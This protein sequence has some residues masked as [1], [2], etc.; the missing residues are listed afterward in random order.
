MREPGSRPSL[1]G[2]VMRL[3]DD[4]VLLVRSELRLVFGE[5][6]QRLAQAVFVQQGQ[7]V[8]VQRGVVVGRGG[9]GG[10]SAASTARRRQ[11]QSGEEG[12][13]HGRKAEG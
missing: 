2:L 9:G 13:G 4:A 8:E 6:S 7:A 10:V 5:F 12:A 1:S 3:V 11:C